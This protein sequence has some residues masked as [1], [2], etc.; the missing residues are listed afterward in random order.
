ML[1]ILLHLLL[2]RLNLLGERQEGRKHQIWHFNS[3][4]SQ[5]RFLLFNLIVERCQLRSVIL[6]LG[7]GDSKQLVLSFGGFDLGSHFFGIHSQI[8]TLVFQL[9]YSLIIALFDL[10]QA[11]E[12]MLVPL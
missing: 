6:S 10:H 9:L 4:F 5:S 11:L 1:L 8:L 7:Q 2:L 3:L 12:L